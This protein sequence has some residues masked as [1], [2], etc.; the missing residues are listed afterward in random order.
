VL[1]VRPWTPFTWPSVAPAKPYTPEAFRLLLAVK[2]WTPY[3]RAE[4][5]DV[6]PVIADVSSAVKSLLTTRFPFTTWAPF[7]VLL[8]VK[9]LLLFVRTTV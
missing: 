1:G 4:R 6:F 3:T 9:V 2:P 8:P 7:R 5:A